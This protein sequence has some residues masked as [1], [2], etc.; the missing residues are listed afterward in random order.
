MLSP[1]ASRV[2]LPTT[3]AFWGKYTH[4]PVFLLG[5][6][7][8]NGVIFGAIECDSRGNWLQFGV[9]SDHVLGLGFMDM[10]DRRRFAVFECFTFQLS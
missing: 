1:R 7:Q 8:V 4:S 3:N 6:W 9:N 10:G 2:E 5:K